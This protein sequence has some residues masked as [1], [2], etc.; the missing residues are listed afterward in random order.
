VPGDRIALDRTAAEQDEEDRFQ[1]LYGRWRPMTPTEF[2]QQMQG[3]DRPWWLVGGWAI[4][5]ATGLRREHEDLD[6]SLLSCDVA[7]FV[8]FM[9]D[10]WHVW[11]NVGGVLHP[12]GDQWPTVDEPRSQ[13]WLRSDAAS[14]WIV[15][16]PLTPDRDGWWTNKLMVDHVAPVDDVT[17]V[18]ASGIRHLR[19][20]IVMLYKARHRRPKD[21]LDLD[22]VLAV[23]PAGRCAWLRDAVAMLDDDH[24]WLPRLVA[25][26]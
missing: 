4:E 24:P 3:F 18:D 8:A 11:N 21:L 22:A 23:L 25:T 2:A 14:P 13:L 9:R 10:R 16:I 5:A 6:V 17:E 19:P 12:L 15:D 26:R 7:A 1:S 20:E